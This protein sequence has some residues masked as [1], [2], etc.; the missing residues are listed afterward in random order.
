[1]YLPRAVGLYKTAVLDVE[2]IMFRLAGLIEEHRRIGEELASLEEVIEKCKTKFE[3]YNRMD[4]ARGIQ[5]A[6]FL[7]PTCFCAWI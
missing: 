4:C 7:S 2:F 1:M 6:I 5:P 3:H